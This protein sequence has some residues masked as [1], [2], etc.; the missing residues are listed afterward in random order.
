VPDQAE[1]LK[2]D[3]LLDLS[4]IGMQLS[5]GYAPEPE[6]STL[7]LVAHHPQAF[8]F[9]MKQGR[10]KDAAATTPDDIIKGSRRDPSLFGAELEDAD[11]LE[12]GVAEGEDAPVAAEA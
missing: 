9:G 11:P 10:L 2:V 4:T 8:Y 5:G 7:A 3:K 1:H 6:Q 12:G